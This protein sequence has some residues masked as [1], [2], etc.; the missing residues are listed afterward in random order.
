MESER[1]RETLWWRMAMIC[2]GLFEQ[3]QVHREVIYGTLLRFF[4]C[5]EVWPAEPVLL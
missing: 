3:C 1:V 2:S 5:Y 4:A